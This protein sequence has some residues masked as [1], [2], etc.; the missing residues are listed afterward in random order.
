MLQKI[1]RLERL[2][3]TVEE[4]KLMMHEKKINWYRDLN[5]VNYLSCLHY[6]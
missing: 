2:E 1:E 3:E 5:S 4:M 6:L